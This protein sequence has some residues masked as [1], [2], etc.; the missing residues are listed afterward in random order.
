MHRTDQK[1]LKDL[2]G[3]LTELHEQQLLNSILLIE[4][5]LLK[6]AD[7][8]IYQLVS[9]LA[10]ELSEAIIYHNDFLDEKEL[11]SEA[12]IRV[13]RLIMSL[14]SCGRLLKTIAHLK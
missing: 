3:V 14:A 4:R 10:A 11:V 5:N 12:I 7:E 8:R 13:A 2:E 9:G 1:T 6:E